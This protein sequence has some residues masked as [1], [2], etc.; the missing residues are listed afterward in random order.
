MSFNRIDMPYVH[1]AEDLAVLNTDY[2]A[3]SSDWNKEK[4]APIKE[5]IIAHL[6]TQQDHHCCYCKNPLGYDLKQVDIEHIIP[7]S[8][9]VRFTFEPK[10]LALSCPSCNTKK[11]IKNVLVSEIKKYP[12]NHAKFLIVHPHFSNYSDHIGLIGGVIY[13][14]IDQR[15]NNTIS[16][17]ELS[18]LGLARNN[19]LK[20]IEQSM[21]PLELDVE[22]IR[23]GNNVEVHNEIYTK[24]NQKISK[25]D[26]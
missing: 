21:N 3:T 6:R 8:T 12:N 15:G 9:H 19:A 24:I 1:T 4:Y 14:G 26:I 16:M 5:R 7:K 13:S 17:C 2:P 25:N 20:S 11:S 18:R 23:T 22:T 10:N